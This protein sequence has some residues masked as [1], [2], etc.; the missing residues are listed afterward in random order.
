[1][2]DKK[3]IGELNKILT[4]EHGHLGMYKNYLEYEDQEIRRTFRRFME[5]EEEHIGKINTVIRNLGGKPSLTV[6]G[7]DIIGKLFGITLNTVADI[8]GQLKVY[9]F[10]EKKSHEGYA[11][12]VSQLEQ[13]T[14]ERNQFIAEIAAANMLEAQLMHLW[15]DNRRRS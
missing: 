11:K 14:Q 3:L 7:G 5:I 13:D 9:S 10:I 2:D 4:L 1:M 15:L 6:D 8:N 12:F